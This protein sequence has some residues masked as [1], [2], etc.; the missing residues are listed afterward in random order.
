MYKSDS[1][2][3][4]AKALIAFQKEVPVIEKNAKNPFFK[5]NYASLDNIIATIKP[6]MAKHG[7]SVSQMPCGENQLKT[8]LIHESGEYIGDDSSTCPAK[9][10]PQGLGSAITYMRRYALCAILGIASEEDDDGNEAT[11]NHQPRYEPVKA[12]TGPVPASKGTNA[13]GKVC[14]SCGKPYTPKPGTESF[15][16][17]CIPC[18]V[19]SKGGKKPVAKEEVPPPINYGDDPMQGIDF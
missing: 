4:L 5:S 12:P 6:V 15:S 1:I 9:Q 8:L 10:D 7:L 2:T 3:A 16:T 14:A 18:F 19:K 13:I 17:V 11:N